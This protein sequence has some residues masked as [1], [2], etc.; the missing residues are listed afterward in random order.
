M[1]VK[2]AFLQSDYIHHEVDLYGEPSGL[3]AEMMGLKE[4]EVVMMMT[5]PALLLEMRGCQGSGTKRL[6]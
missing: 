5:K 2:P 6:I 1:D 4:H 3:L